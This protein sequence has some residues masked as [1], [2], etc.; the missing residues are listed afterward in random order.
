MT[1]KK[2][3]GEIARFLEGRLAGDES[4]VVTGATNIEA[5]GST[6]ITFA[7][8]PHIEEAKASQAAAV[9]LPED[10]QGFPCEAF[11]AFHASAADSRG[12]QSA[13]FRGEDRR[14]GRGCLDSSLCR[15]R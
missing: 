9:L 4:I 14:G 8:P 1:M 3:L 15:R 12:R 6:E 13:G 11:G 2:T 10:V 7:A 5:A